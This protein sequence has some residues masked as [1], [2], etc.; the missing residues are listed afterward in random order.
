VEKKTKRE[1]EARSYLHRKMD[2]ST[3]KL[4]NPNKQKR[5]WEGEEFA[6]QIFFVSV[7]FGEEKGGVV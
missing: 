6:C 5:G 7:R 2:I 4:H 3:A 1:R